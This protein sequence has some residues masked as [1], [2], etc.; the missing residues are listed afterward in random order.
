MTVVPAGKVTAA[1]CVDAAAV[2]VEAAGADW[3][4]VITGAVE[5]GAAVDAA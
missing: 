1:G 2:V 4:P 3:P 5:G